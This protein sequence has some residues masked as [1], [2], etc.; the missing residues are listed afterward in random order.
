MIFSRCG[1]QE[2]NYCLLHFII[3]PLL[4]TDLPDEPKIF[5]LIALG[6]ISLV[7]ADQYGQ[8]YGY[9]SGS[10]CT[11]GSCSQGQYNSGYYQGQPSNS[12]YYQGQPYNSGYYQGQPNNSGYYQG[13]SNNAGN[14]QAQPNN[15]GYYQQPNT[16]NP[17]NAQPQ[18]PRNQYNQNQPSAQQQNY[19]AY[20]QG[21][22]ANV[23][24][25]YAPQDG[26]QPKVAADQEIVKSVRNL[27]SAGVFSNGYPDVTFEV[28]N[29]NVTLKGSV[30]TLENKNTIEADVK[31]IN[32]VN[33]VTNKITIVKTSANAYSET[34]LQDSE[35]KYPSDTA[36]TSNDRQ[37]NAKIRDKLSG[38]V[39][40]K[41]YEFLVIKT[42]NGVVVIS[43]TVANS[44]DIKKVTD[45]V[46]ELEGVKSVK[47]QLTVRK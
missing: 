41:G 26:N 45:K 39:F 25:T 27:L 19:R 6:S 30:D 34:Q 8:P 17:N 7:S 33:Q 14:Y 2:T 11:N 43:G 31:K 46:K 42:T 21:Q 13:Q 15:A 3:Y 18:A 35:R 1:N 44:D 28:Y 9:Q 36:A 47:N 12:G 37:L 10:S 32:G 38:G 40:S 5:S 20:N 16:G 4:C 22:Q 29:G 23:D 24:H